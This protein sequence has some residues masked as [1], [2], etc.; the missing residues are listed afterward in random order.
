MLARKVRALRSWGADA[1][2]VGVASVSEVEL[3]RVYRAVRDVD[4]RAMETMGGVIIE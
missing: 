1:A 3:V 2:A 4:A